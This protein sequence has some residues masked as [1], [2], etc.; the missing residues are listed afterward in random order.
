M[1]MGVN[2]AQILAILR[3]VHLFQ[4]LNDERLED[5]AAYFDIVQFPD[6]R[7]IYKQ[8]AEPDNFY[9]LISGSV[10]LTFEENGTTN[11]VVSL[12]SGDYFGEEAL[13]NSFDQRIVSA[14]A[15]G[16]TTLLMLNGTQVGDLVKE[17]PEL[18]NGFHQILQSY[19]LVVSRT[20]SWLDNDEIVHFIAHRHPI[21]L[22][23]ML[24]L[25]LLLAVLLLIPLLYVY[26][27]LS[28]HQSLLLAGAGL[29]MLVIM[30]WG[31]LASVEWNNDYYVVTNHRLILIRKVILLYESRQEVPLDAI[32]TIGT[33]SSLWG[34]LLNY[35]NVN[36]RTY[37]GS[38]VF[39][40][41]GDPDQVAAIIVQYLNQAKNSTKAVQQEAIEE[42]IRQRFKK[43]TMKNSVDSLEDQY[44]EIEVD[45][46]SGVVT[47][48]LSN[49]FGLREEKD[50]AI[51]YRTHWFLLLVKTFFPNL[52]I[53]G[54]AAAIILRLS[55][56]FSAVPAVIFIGFCLLLGFFAWLWW[57]YQYV[58][59]HNDV[60]I[61]TNDQIVDVYRKPLAEEDR[62]AAPLKNIQ[63]IEYKRKNIFGIIFNF[64]TVFIRVGDQDFTFD[65][66]SNPSEVQ[67]ELFKRFMQF[68]Q[69]EKQV[70]ADAER[71][72]IGDWMEAYHK[73][74]G[75]SG[76]QKPS[77][78]GISG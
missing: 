14:T 25:P 33:T 52:V 28:V 60:Y 45:V 69:R 66:V 46:R 64:G 39:K 62:R 73:I 19:R 1:H 37:T 78:P 50:G 7:S 51:I 9:I 70:A 21:V 48:A 41:L 57:I 49:L 12:R 18:K 36:I 4:A 55:G 74:M 30:V 72:R 77:D 63:S 40:T 23:S 56:Q 65:N 59:W 15:K 27:I 43:N 6:N 58:D 11:K 20:F 44:Q 53:L 68:N 35:G 5:V 10:I 32:L 26:F 24:F 17:F 54:L 47:S 76:G 71:Q 13:S 8:Y 34:R 29:V 16:N 31:V 38:L 3:S 67:R 2:P 75:E 22:A 42:S 61:I